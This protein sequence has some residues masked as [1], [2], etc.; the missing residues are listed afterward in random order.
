M[1]L[2]RVRTTLLLACLMSFSVQA[3]SWGYSIGDTSL[4]IGEINNEYKSCQTGV[5]QSPINIQPTDTSKLGLPILTM[6]YTDSPVRFQSINHTLQAT[7]NS[8]TLIPS[9]STISFTI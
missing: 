4:N 2:I 3:S 8:Y 7:M 6:Q 9:T 1:Y 5:N